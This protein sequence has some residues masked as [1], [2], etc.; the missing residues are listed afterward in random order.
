MTDQWAY[1]TADYIKTLDRWSLDDK[2]KDP[3][4][5]PSTRKEWVSIVNRRYRRIYQA[6]LE[7]FLSGNGRIL[8][9]IFG[10]GVMHRKHKARI[11]GGF[12]QELKQLYNDDISTTKTSKSIRVLL[13]WTR[14]NFLSI[15]RHRNVI[16]IPKRGS[17][18]CPLCGL[19]RFKFVAYHIIWLCRA[20]DRSKAL[21][22]VNNKDFTENIVFLE[23]IQAEI[24]RL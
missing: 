19:N 7:T 12:L 18:L 13:N 3:N 4:N 15:D 21:T 22:W 10:R 1:T 14:F 23:G 6:E 16:P 9:L 8:A 20:V 24:S 2:Y 17:G 11:Y 5:L